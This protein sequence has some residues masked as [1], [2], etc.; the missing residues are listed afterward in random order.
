MVQ[1]WQCFEP[2]ERSFIRKISKQKKILKN[3]FRSKQ[4]DFLVIIIK[5]KKTFS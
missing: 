1:G 4:R 5:L 3:L 2:N